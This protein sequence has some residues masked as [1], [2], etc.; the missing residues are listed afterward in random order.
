MYI[1]QINI[2]KQNRVYRDHNWLTAAPLDSDKVRDTWMGRLCLGIKPK[3]H[4]VCCKEKYFMN[5]LE[6]ANHKGHRMK[7]IKINHNCT[8]ARILID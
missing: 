7:N 1:S 5:R 4:G 2:V 3:I 6:I 8:W